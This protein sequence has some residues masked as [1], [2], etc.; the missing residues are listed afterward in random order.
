[1]K[2]ICLLLILPQVFN[3]ATSEKATRFNGLTTESG[4]PDHYLRTTSYGLN[5]LVIFPIKRNAEFPE[6]VEYFSDVAKKNKG[7][8]IRIIQKE[9]SKW[10]LVFPPI[11]FFL[12]PVIT[13]IVGEVY[14]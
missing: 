5:L 10:F 14:D 1:M 3:C 8:K 4:K 2:R 11:S 12:T 6:A 7:S 9:T 13:E